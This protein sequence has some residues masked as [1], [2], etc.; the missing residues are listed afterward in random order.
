MDLRGE[1][2]YDFYFPRDVVAW[3]DRVHLPRNADRVLRE[4]YD[5]LEER[6]EEWHGLVV[7]GQE[8]SHEYEEEMSD[9]MI[10]LR[11]LLR[12][13]YSDVEEGWEST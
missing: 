8:I 2:P 4:A 1:T 3:F 11:H 12:Y 7:E 6:V 10:F 9:M 13:G 5:M